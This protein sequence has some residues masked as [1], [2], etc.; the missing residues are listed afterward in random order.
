MYHHHPSIRPSVRLSHRAFESSVRLISFH[1]PTATGTGAG[2]GARS[3]L[4]PMT[5]NF[6]LREPWGC[7][8]TLNSKSISISLSI[9][10]SLC[11]LPSLGI[12][13]RFSVPSLLPPRSRTLIRWSCLL[14][15]SDCTPL[16]NSKSSSIY[17][18]QS[19]LSIHASLCQSLP[20]SG[21]ISPLFNH[22]YLPPRSRTLIRWS[23][24][25]TSNRLIGDPM[26]E[27][28]RIP[29]PKFRSRSVEAG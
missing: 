15:V 5:N 27:N 21:H 11:H 20:E 23:C 18:Y 6:G 4:M 29:N 13:P 16:V 14:L 8:P 12:F 25:L 2:T 28:S 26:D 1:T 24:L 9:H 10:A 22:F 3:R 7:T 19:S 17:L